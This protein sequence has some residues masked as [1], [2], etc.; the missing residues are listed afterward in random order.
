MRAKCR[1][2]PTFT[3]IEREE[4]CFYPLEKRKKGKKGKND[5]NRCLLGDEYET[6]LYICR[7]STCTLS[8]YL[9]L[10]ISPEERIFLTLKKREE[11]KY[12][13]RT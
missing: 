13:N 6:M 8:F 10:S 1:P 9:S 12:N 2:K 5:E 11:K 7:I 3:Q 4:N